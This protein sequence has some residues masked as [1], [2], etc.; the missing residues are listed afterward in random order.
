MTESNDNIVLAV[1]F[2][3]IGVMLLAASTMMLQLEPSV[4]VPAFLAALPA[5][6]P[7]IGVAGFGIWSCWRK[8]APEQPRH[9]P[10]LGGF[11]WH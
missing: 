9:A 1:I 11:Q 6:A 10:R 3:I 7:A 4:H 8:P 2:T 5:I